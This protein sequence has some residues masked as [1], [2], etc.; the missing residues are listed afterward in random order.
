VNL[1]QPITRYLSHGLETSR[2][3][4][5][6]VALRSA[7]GRSNSLTTSHIHSRR[8]ILTLVLSLS[9]S[10]PMV[11]KRRHRHSK[12]SSSHARSSRRMQSCMMPSVNIFNL[13]NS[14][15]N[16]Q[17]YTDTVTTSIFTA[18]FKVN[19]GWLALRRHA[20]LC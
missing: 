3:G 14:P 10:Q 12:L 18:F 2:V 1:F 9:R 4:L 11:V 7:L 15:I 19:P 16:L 17:T 13:N 8:R 6:S 20:E 5:N